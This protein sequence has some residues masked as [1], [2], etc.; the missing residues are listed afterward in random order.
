MKRSAVIASVLISI[1]LAG[2]GFGLYRWKMQ[3]FAAAAAAN[4]GMAPPPESIT[5]ATVGTISWQPTA[6]LVGTAL[7]MRSVTLGAEVAGTIREVGFES[8]SIVEAGQVLVTLDDSTERADLEAA[9]SSVPVAEASVT[10]AESSL[11]W[12]SATLERLNQ[13]ITSGATSRADLDEA[14]AA[15]DAATAALQRAKAEVILAHARVDQIKALINRKTLRAP[16]RAVAG[17]RNVHPGQFL[18]EGAPIVMLQEATDDIYVDFALPQQHIARVKVG[19]AV[20]ATSSVFGKEPRRIEVVAIDAAANATTRN[21]RIRS[22][23][24]NRDKR[25]RPG[26]FVDVRVP[27]GPAQDFVAIP[28]TAVRRASYGDHVFV[29]NQGAGGAA[30]PGGPMGVSQRFVKLGPSV[31]TD[32]IILEGLKPGELVA[33]TGSFK[34]REGATV[35]IMPPTNSTPSTT[36]SATTSTTPSPTTD[37]PPAATSAKN[38]A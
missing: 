38:P 17:L 23:V 20:M 19:D 36:P 31:G 15:V 5:A 14:R 13:A 32:L 1:T 29:I 18:A 8:G 11:L 2:V 34:L 26:M 25:L 24:D 3:S 28:N 21:V 22:V 6:D 12:S 9:Q 35:V 7:A 37:A 33:T 16:F 30:P 27:V 4:A 10:A